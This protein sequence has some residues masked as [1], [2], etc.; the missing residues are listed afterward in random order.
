MAKVFCGSVALRGKE[1]WRKKGR[2]REWSSLKSVWRE[3]IDGE[4]RSMLKKREKANMD[5]IISWVYANSPC[6]FLLIGHYCI[7]YFNSH[8]QATRANHINVSPSTKWF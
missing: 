6:L 8:T 5:E 7:I 2:T 3:E 4:R 1:V